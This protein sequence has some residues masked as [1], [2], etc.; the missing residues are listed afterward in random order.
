MLTLKAYQD[1]RG[2]S[3]ASD[4]ERREW[5]ARRAAALPWLPG[6]LLCCR[7]ML[8]LRAE[9]DDRGTSFASDEERREWH[10]RR[11]EA[12]ER[13]AAAER[14]YRRRRQDGLEVRTS[15]SGLGLSLGD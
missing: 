9:Q 12:A 1:D 11:A 6:A 14:C 8:T 10:A 4:E 13:L 3:F 15:D 2:T 7:D 5:H